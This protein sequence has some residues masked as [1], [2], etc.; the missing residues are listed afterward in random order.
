MKRSSTLLVAALAFVGGGILAFTIAGKGK[1]ND[2]VKGKGIE[3][4]PGI[5]RASDTMVSR[6]FDLSG[7]SGIEISMPCTVEVAHG[8]TF[9]IEASVPENIADRLKAEVKGQTLVFSLDEDVWLAGT[10]IR[11]EMT[12]PALGSLEIN[13]IADVTFTGFSET[14][15]SIDVSGAAKIRGR[16]GRAKDARINSS[17][18]AQIDF[19]DFITENARLDISG[20][21][22]V[23]LTMGGGDLTGSISG[24]AK[25]TYG[26][27]VRTQNVETSG[28]GSVR[29]R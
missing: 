27:E 6:S 17:G 24:A 13:G 15:F 11:I 25:V 14:D 18:A 3:S 7:F 10:K 23:S 2:I 29:K 12:M 26:G 1:I 8:D 5:T 22:E 20:A 9:L 28:V 21:A 16:D 19:V 4:L